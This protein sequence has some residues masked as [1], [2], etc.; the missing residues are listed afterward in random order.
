[1]VTYVWFVKKKKQHLNFQPIIYLFNKLGFVLSK[2]TR[3]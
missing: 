3:I 1:M 2:P